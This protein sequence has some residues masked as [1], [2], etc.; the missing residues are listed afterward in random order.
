MSF[1]ACATVAESAGAES[2]ET[3][4]AGVALVTAVGLLED[5]LEGEVLAQPQVVA[6][7][8]VMSPLKIRRFILRL[9][10]GKDKIVLYSD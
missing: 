6:A 10:G 3:A 8:S 5:E 2:A 7:A 9:L 1:G 4:A